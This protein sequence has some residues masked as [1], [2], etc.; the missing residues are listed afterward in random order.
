MQPPYDYSPAPIPDRPAVDGLI[1]ATTALLPTN[2]ARALEIV[3]EALTLA[4]T[5]E[6]GAGQTQAQLLC[7][8]ALH[9][10]ARLQ[11]AARHLEMA[12]AGF[13]RL[14]MP[15]GE[16]QALTACAVVMRELG[17]PAR[18]QEL[19]ERALT[20]S[21]QLGDLELQATVLNHQA[22][23][24][25]TSGNASLALGQLQAAL[26]IRHQ[27]GDIL[28]AAQCLN[29]IGQVHLSRNHLG[30]ALT[31]LTEAFELLKTVDDPTTTAHCLINIA[32]VH[33]ELGDHQQ[34]YDYHA[35]AL[36]LARQQHN[37]TLELYCLNNLA[38]AVSNLHRFQE[39]AELFAKALEMAQEIGIRYLM[40]CAYHG[41]GRSALGQGHPDAALQQ[42]LLALEIAEELG[43]QESEVD[44]LL[45]L[46]EVH[47][48][49]RHYDD[50]QVHLQRALPLALSHE[51]P[52]KVA[53][54]RILLA[55]V[56]QAT[57]QLNEALM[58]LW[59]VR[60]LERELFDQERDRT[61]QQLTVQF[62]VERAH[63]EAA[64]SQ[65]QTEIANQAFQDAEAKVSEQTKRLVQTQVEV[66]TR[67][68]NAAE[69]RDDVTGEHTLR[70]GHIAALLAEH[71][72]L[73][74]EQVSILRVA[75]R[76]HDVGKIGIS[77]MILQKPAK[78][79]IEEYEV[80]K[81]HTLIG[82]KILSGGESLLLNMAEEI[83]LCHHEH[84]DGSGYPRG[85]KGEAIPLVARIVAVADVYDALSYS[86][87]Y[88]R[89][90]S[91]DEV[92]AELSRQSG[93]Q[94]Q[95]EIVSALKAIHASGISLLATP[96]D[97]AQLQQV[98]IEQSR[99]A[100]GPTTAAPLM[101]GEPRLALQLRELEARYRDACQRIDALQ[102]AAFTDPLT[103]LANRR[104]FE[105]E[106][107]TEIL[108]A[109]RHHYPVS[110]VSVDLD[111][112]K[113]VN[114]LEGHERGDA[115]LIQ[116]AQAL[117]SH[118]GYAGRLY[119]IGGDEF[120]VI[121]KDV[122][123]DQQPIFLERL[124]RAVS[125][126]QAAGFVSASMSAGIAS[127]PEEATLEGDLLRLSD[128]RMYVSKL[129]RR[130]G[131]GNYTTTN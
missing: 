45:G 73:S 46:G 42:Y 25:Q 80:M 3:T 127:F 115:L 92:M 7:G 28:G 18:A 68:A 38:Q 10:L 8:Q 76:L 30:T 65:V 35:R 5:L 72:Q 84:W 96:D 105:D 87:P 51:L 60:E 78:L 112:L 26:A 23:L 106:L 99:F 34:S 113:M 128:Q 52:K 64:V 117:R 53:R 81:S 70:V 91:H 29:N 111:G 36:A 121:V 123:V 108:H 120:A 54:I 44:A 61:T 16:T 100:T 74:A 131:K 126:V 19:L 118:V 83:A 116:M 67:L 20:L 101:H 90:W 85:L 6:Y 11:E 104:A 9:R 31:T 124:S 97:H 66:V 98:L 27:L 58:Q 40:G 88:K 77:D 13:Q 107:E 122:D 2:P 55:Q 75:A 93:R 24:A 94:F 4:T 114:D 130:Q 50:A 1:A 102:V 32:Y 95:P 86:R 109:V 89:A 119:R 129:A 69:Y 62:D 22:A 37:H 17:E 14:A 12:T 21:T 79:T 82:G 57:G 125:D 59:T 47:V 48:T 71:L 41:L 49:L 103:G 15:L 43:E 63:H 56:A 33:E 39:A 110:V